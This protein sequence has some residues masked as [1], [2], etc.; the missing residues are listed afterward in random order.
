MQVSEQLLPCM[1][2]EVQALWLLAGHHLP[3]LARAT[4]LSAAGLTAVQED[5]ITATAAVQA[6]IQLC[7]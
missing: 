3:A 1:V 2:Q 7:Q 6:L 4:S 5:I